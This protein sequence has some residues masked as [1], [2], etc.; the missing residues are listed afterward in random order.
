M[1][2]EK[3]KTT[4]HPVI[5]GGCYVHNVTGEEAVILGTHVDPNSGKRM[6]NMYTFA[7]G[8]LP[9]QVIEHGES[10]RQWTLVSAPSKKTAT[11]LIAS[12]KRHS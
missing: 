3:E 9:S 11:G 5:N 7:R 4:T 8:P 12:S 6:G 10:M 2:E 1:T